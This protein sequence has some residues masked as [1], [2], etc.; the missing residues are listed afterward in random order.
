MINR[1]RGLSI[2]VMLLAGLLSANPVLAGVRVQKM[3]TAQESSNLKSNPTGIFRINDQVL[4][5]NLGSHVVYV[6][7]IPGSRYLTPS[8]A[9]IIR[10]D[11]ELT[12][13]PNDLLDVVG[14]SSGEHTGTA[15]LA[16]DHRTIVFTPDFPFALGDSVTV[17][18]TRPLISAAGD[19]IRINTFSFTVSATDLDADK[20]VVSQIGY[21]IPH[22][23]YPA[24]PME[25]LGGAMGRLS[26][27]ESLGDE[28]DSLPSD[29]P[30]PT[31]TKSDSPSTGYIFLATNM[32]HAFYEKYGNYM[33][34]LNNSGQVMYY[35]NTGVD[36]AWNF[37]IQPG[38]QVTYFTPYGNGWFYIMNSSLQVVD[39]LTARDGYFGDGHE[40]RIFPDG[41]IFILADDYQFVDMSKIVPGG[42]PYAKLIDV[43]IQEFD[44][45]GNLILNWR[46]I[47]HF[48]ITD[49][50]GQNLDSN[51]VDPFHCNAIERDPDGDI[52]LSSRHLS[53]ITKINPDSGSIVWHLGGKNNEFTFANDT[54]GF[55]YQHD[56]RRLS[57]G[58]ITLMDNGNM[59]APPFSR[60][61]EYK[62]D[63]VSKIATL[64]WQFR[65]IPEAY[66]PF[67]GNVERLSNGN[68]FIGWGGAATPAI[69]E[70][71]PDGSTA[72]ELTFPTDS[73]WSYRS[74]RFP[75]LFVTAPE[76]DDTVHAGSDATLKWMSSGVGTV[77]IDCS[78]DGGMTWSTLAVNYPARTDS[79]TFSVS[80]DSA[81]SVQFR[82]VQSGEVDRGL[83]YY[84]DSVAVSS[85]TTGVEPIAKPYTY[86]LFNNYPNPFNPSTMISYQLAGPG[87]VTLT[88][89]D[90][91]GREV[92][93]LV[94][95]VQNAGEHS[96]K[97][98]GSRF[99]SGVYFYR[100]QTSSGFSEVKK[101][102][103]E[104]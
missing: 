20:A 87:H 76:A 55:S 74:F 103:L 57:N 49:A 38:G 53:E 47:D 86:K 30:I 3:S 28:P 62:L 15:V 6:S 83:T 72:W 26:K 35:R 4:D 16:D 44:K 100:L 73:V 90:I 77:D 95:A 8:A 41:N 40:I 56:I 102:I 37:T 48:K 42:N 1:Y 31:V 10:S 67:M 33:M 82:I 7:P 71:K 24:V 50:L 23:H 45:S 79:I 21:G 78:Y 99:A 13:V 52:L 61:V 101:M 97:F 68:T 88:I 19:T 89:Y 93:T 66:N 39:S 91:L 92:A 27:I 104:K 11:E 43:V 14:S 54:I 75:F 5:K 9:I 81:T 17:S 65:H 51:V 58:D 12:S 64:D 84:T 96:V 36:P 32:N 25:S 98:D 69:T 22:I 34:I 2:A 46:C 59:H 18:M 85:V 63:E 70:V 29:L 60:A 94:N 80:S